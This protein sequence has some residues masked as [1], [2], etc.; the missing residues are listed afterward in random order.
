MLSSG[1]YL[2]VVRFMMNSHKNFQGHLVFA[3]F[4]AYAVSK[5]SDRTG[6]SIVAYGKL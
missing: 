2:K 4:S 6:L 1:G 3:K 5:V